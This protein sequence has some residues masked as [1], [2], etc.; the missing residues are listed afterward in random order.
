M[1]Q[2]HVFPSAVSASKYPAYQTSSYQQ[3]QRQIREAQK[4]L[5]PQQL[6]SLCYILQKFCLA[7]TLPVKKNYPKV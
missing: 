4:K 3:N 1:L 7:S 2:H 5:A 6:T